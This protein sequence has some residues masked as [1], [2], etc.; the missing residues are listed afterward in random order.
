MRRSDITAGAEVYYAAGQHWRS[1]PPTRAIVVTA[2]RY[3]IVR[4]Q[5][6]A[7]GTVSYVLDAAGS[8]VLV[9]LDEGGTKMRRCAVP[10]RDLRGLWK[11]TL[12]ATGRTA[13]GV[14]ARNAALSDLVASGR[15]VTGDDLLRLAAT[16]EGVSD[17]TFIV[18][19]E[20]LN[21][22]A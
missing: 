9:D 20:H 22:T 1:L 3:R 17:A 19:A 21:G 5:Q 7:F 8:A 10:A 15:P 4:S 11:P 2:D 6:G 16:D 12:A 14:K 18:L 13:A